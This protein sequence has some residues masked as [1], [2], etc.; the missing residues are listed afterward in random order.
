VLTGKELELLDDRALGERL[1]EVSVL[2][3]VA[4]E[5]KL[6]IVRALK[7]SG[8][9]VAVT[10]DGV[11]DAPAMKA[12]DI[13]IAMGRAGTDVAREASDMVLTDD[14]FVSIHAAVEEGRV[15]F[16]NLRK[17]TFF[18]LCTSTAEIFA[19]LGAQALGWPLPLLP[20]QLLWLNLVT[21]SIQDLALAFEPGDPDVLRQRPR[22]RHAGILSPLLWERMIVA[23]LVMT[24]GTLLLFRMELVA[25]ASIVRAQ[26]VALTTMVLFQMFQVGMARSERRSA[27]S[28]SPL[29]N[30][31]LLIGTILATALHA[32]VLSLPLTHRLLH[33]EALDVRSWITMLSVAA[34]IIPAMELHKLLRSRWPRAEG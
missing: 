27:F 33:L 1:R 3:R 20:V 16:S 8:E 18:L 10:G 19:V 23:G 2:A 5:H 17:V 7:E 30:P 29:S 26:T 4:P 6:R 13:G 24:A 21:N 32:G 15:T 12:A 34:S 25:G 22:P 14:N 11:N 28:K 9:V 31:A